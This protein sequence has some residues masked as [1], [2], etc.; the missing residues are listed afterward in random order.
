MKNKTLQRILALVLAFTFLLGGALSTSA[1]TADDAGSTTDKTLAEIREQLNAITYE[2]YME[3]YLDVPRATGAI[4]IPGVDYTKVEGVSADQ[5]HKVEDEDGNVVALYTPNAGTI[6]WNV[7]GITAPAKY[8]VVIEYWPDAAKSASIERILKINGSIPFAE[9]RYLTLPKVWQNKYT[10]AELVIEKKWD[11]TAE[12]LQAEALAAGFATAE[13]GDKRGEACLKLSIPTVWTKELTEFV[14][15]YEVRFVT[16]DIDN[17]ELRPGMTQTPEWRTYELRD[18][19]GFYA[20]SFE[21]VFAPGEDGNTTISLEA[22]NEPMSITS[23]TLIPHEDLI[24]YDEYLKKY[25]GIGS[26]SDWLTIQAE[27]VGATSSQTIYP[28]EDRTDAATMPSDTGR[29]VLNTIGG[30]KWQTAGQWVRYSFK[31]S[32]S[33]MY[34][35][36]ARYRQNVLDGMYVCRS[37]RLLSE[38]APEGSLGYYDGSVP[39]YEATQTRFN[40]N[41][42]WQSTILNNGGDQGAFQFYFEKDVVYTVTMEV[43][44]GSTGNIVRRVSEILNAINNDYLEIM[45]LTGADPD[46]YRDYGFARI[47]PDVMIDMIINSR[48][49]YEV[50]AELAKISGEKSSN[51]A[52]LEKV[53]WLLDRMGGDEDEIAKYLD[54]LK[55]YI[56]S[57]GTWLSDAKTQPLQLD[58]I[59][60]QPLEQE[61]PK[62]KAGFFAAMLHEIKSFIMS[63]FRNYDRMGATSEDA[64]GDETVEVWLAYGRD[65]AQVIRSLINNDFSPNTNI[66]VDLKLVAGGT[67]LPSVLAGRGPDVYIGVGE[68][69][70][71]NYAIRGALLP[72]EKMDGFEEFALYYKV[73]DKFNPLVDDAGNP[74]RNP[75]AQFNQAA[76]AVLGISDAEGIHHYYGLPETQNFTMMFVREDILADLGIEIPKTWDDVF[77]AIPTLQ[78]NNML[79]GGTQDYKIFLYQM[80]GTLFADDGMRINLD[81]DVGLESFEFMCNFFTMYSFPKSYDFANRF[82][83]GE[84]PIGFASYNGTYNHLTVFATE[85]KGLWG[86]YPLPGF[87]HV[88]ADGT[89]Y[90]DNSS[91]ATTSAIVMLNGCDTPEQQ[92]RAWE[93]MKWHSGADCQVKYS[94]E[95]VA[96]LGPSAKH[97]TANITAL[98]EMPWTSEELT[99]LGY[100]FN[101]LASIPNYPGSYII[102]RYT[103]FA[104]LAAYEDNKNPIEELQRYI[105]TINKEITRKR[106]EFG[107]ETLEI[108]QT[109]LSKRLGQLVTAFDEASEEL[110]ADHAT[111]KSVN[112]LLEASFRHI[113][114]EDYDLVDVVDL[115]A[116]LEVVS[117]TNENALADTAKALERAIAVIEGKR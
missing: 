93:F 64:G 112:L 105:T 20:E 73:D 81:S 27:Y 48:K 75:N 14:N 110:G 83:T 18:A 35:I 87:E 103:G 34:N 44:L 28:L 77:A 109:L 17:N 29:V 38:G 49:L 43:T 13:I 6:T 1:A 60:I 41:S 56:G 76:M 78:A 3:K 58:Y 53:A 111:I 113:E 40:Y 74:I 26:G 52:T 96:I 8:S 94:N 101:N 70:V 85:I 98:S 82:R 51:V 22:V 33:G 25:E 95:M 106:E 115:K 23:I 90:I 89:T 104:F 47:M 7:P 16:S 67:L 11:K 116:A 72:I 5:V 45:K 37:I 61:A 68:D 99:Q 10:T 84:M 117:A 36:A 100:Q 32:S 59:V 69:D 42:A 57:L 88:R 39:F 55:S 92:A 80:G 2:A 86:F 12:Q 19:D 71:I 15:T 31:V 102:G 9:A 108:G 24:G 65:Q 4:V 50:A 46:E 30:D 91:V 54:Q 62:A 107:L 66:T 97:A 21:F 79:I 114:R 63:F